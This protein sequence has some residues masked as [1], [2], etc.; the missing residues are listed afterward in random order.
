MESSSPGDEG[1]EVRFSDISEQRTL[2]VR[3]CQVVYRHANTKLLPGN[4]N[5]SS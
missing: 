2:F 3:V 4:G 5:F 1:T